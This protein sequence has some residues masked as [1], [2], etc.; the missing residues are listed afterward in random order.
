MLL[1]G[2]KALV[3]GKLPDMPT[4]FPLVKVLTAQSGP[5]VE[6]LMESFGL[7]LSLCL[8]SAVT[9]S[10]APTAARSDSPA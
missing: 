10:P 1:G 6:W 8:S 7:D 2:K 3:N 4:T 9:R 5:A